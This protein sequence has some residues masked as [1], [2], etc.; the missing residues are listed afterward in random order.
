[1]E[2]VLI[3]GAGPVGLMLACELCL[4]GVRPVVLEK[5]DEPSGLPKANGIGGQI[6]DLLDHRGLLERFSAGSPFAGRATG[7][8]FAGVPLRFEGI[9]DIPFKL[10]LI[11]QP[12]LERLLAER[13]R[14]LGVEIRR[15]SEV[16]SLTQDEEGVTLG[17]GDTELRAR[18][19]VG[20]DG[21]RSGVR[22]WA[23][24]AFPGTT[25]EEGLLIGHF[26]ADIKVFD[27]LEGDGLQPGWNR[28]PHGRVLLTSLRD[29]VLIAGV[30]EPATLPDGPV[31]L[32]DF[33]A[34]V[35]RVL[36]RDVPLGEPI[37]LSSTLSQARLADRYRAGRVFVAGDAAHLFPAGGS[38]LN[39]G[40][41]DAVNL[42]WKLA[43]VLRGRMPAALLDTYESER[44][45]IGARTLMQTRAQAA[46]DRVEGEN[47][48]ALRD[49]LGEIFAF[50][51]PTRHVARLLHDSGLAYG[52]PD[53]PLTGRFVPD[54]KLSDGRR[55]AD[56]MHAARPLLL[57]LG[58]G[59]NLEDDWID[60]VHTR[61]ADAP[62]DALLIRPD[63]YVAWAGTGGTDGL[64]E[65]VSTW[66]TPGKS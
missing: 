22:E 48:Q 52:S 45:P 46:V 49:L 53:H 64:A 32:D 23:G 42:A 14:E 26:K 55:V 36:G 59:A 40:M 33:R 37:W 65:A 66:F 3:V 35:R 24:I 1:M 50:E 31:T 30:R 12:H 44:R 20:C 29:G 43:A 5:R 28:T 38:A 54:L 17:T 13:A 16:T 27:S 34:A 58:G 4:A 63:G 8:P 9:D 7:F 25:D 11:Q 41:T 2:D 21:A 19:V 47:G 57:D 6:V 61:C 15:G 56:L 39:V 10:M 18:Y 60:V 51:E 62:A